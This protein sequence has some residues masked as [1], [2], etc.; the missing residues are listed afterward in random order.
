MK[1]TGTDGT[2]PSGSGFDQAVP[3]ERHPV[4]NQYS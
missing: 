3:S 2:I 1:P 4:P